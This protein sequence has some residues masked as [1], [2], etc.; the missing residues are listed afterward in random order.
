MLMTMMMMMMTASCLPRSSK[1]DGEPA[2]TSSSSHFLPPFSFLPFPLPFFVL[3]LPCS[4]K[5]VAETFRVN[6]RCLCPRC[7][8]KKISQK[9]RTV[10]ELIPMLQDQV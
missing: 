8:P 9:L 10:R 1:R 6:N 5:I 3:F 2:E 4:E 7:D